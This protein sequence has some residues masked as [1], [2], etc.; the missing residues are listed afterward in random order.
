MATSLNT[1][2]KDIPLKFAAG[3]TAIVNQA[4]ED[5][6]FLARTAPVTRDLL[7]FWFNDSFCDARPINFH[8]GQRQA[9]L[10]TIYLHEIAKTGSVFDMYSHVGEYGGTAIAAEMDITYLKKDKF[11]HPKYC[12]KMATGT[13]K[14]WVLNALLIWQYLNARIE[15]TPSGRYS[16]RFLIK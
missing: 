10:N 1:G 4:W 16:K 6:N 11:S 7:R 8:A 14:T 15:D 5:S 9:I 13:G 2:T 3:L 12:L